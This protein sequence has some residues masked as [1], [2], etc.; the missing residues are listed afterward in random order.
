[1]SNKQIARVWD[2]RTLVQQLC[3]VKVSNMQNGP[4]DAFSEKICVDQTINN[5]PHGHNDFHAK[6][7]LDR[8]EYCWSLCR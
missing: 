3:N 6:I 7:D 1:M 5:V 2:L 8:A 4:E